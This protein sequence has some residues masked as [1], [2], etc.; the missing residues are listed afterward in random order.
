MVQHNPM[1]A[2]E[3]RKKKNKPPSFQKALNSTKDQIITSRNLKRLRLVF[4]NGRAPKF[5]TSARHANHPLAIIYHEAQTA[6]FVSGSDDEPREDTL[7]YDLML[8]LREQG[9]EDIADQYKKARQSARVILFDQL[10]N[11][12]RPFMQG[13]P[14]GNLKTILHRA[15][16]IE[17]PYALSLTPC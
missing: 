12:Y 4:V 2:K 8:F 5:L 7:Q 16:L 1:K 17:E 13:L 3:K 9:L 11:R 14:D 15:A 6:L 10:I